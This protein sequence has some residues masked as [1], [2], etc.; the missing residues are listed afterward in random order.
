MV[1]LSL[2]IVLFCTIVITTPYRLLKRVK[3]N[4]IHLLTHLGENGIEIMNGFQ[5]LDLDVDG[6]LP[7]EIV[8]E[9]ERDGLLNESL[10]LKSILTVGH[11]NNQ[12]MMDL[13]GR[14]T[15]EIFLVSFVAPRTTK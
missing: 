15:G 4:A 6:R 12:V 14:K 13:R 9:R 5:A 11:S 3:P 2:S 10:H 8:V 7:I 1:I